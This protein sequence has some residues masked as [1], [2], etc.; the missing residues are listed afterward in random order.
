[1]G[2]ISE[3]TRLERLVA[4]LSPPSVLYKG[5]AEAMPGG[6]T[7][8]EA[9]MKRITAT[10]LFTL[11][12]MFGSLV[13]WAGLAGAQGTKPMPDCYPGSATSHLCS[14][15]VH[16]IP[17]HPGGVGAGHGSGG[18]PTSTT[19]VLVDAQ[20]LSSSSL[21]FTG[22]D[23]AAVVIV[24]LALVGSGLILVRVSRRRRIA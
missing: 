6:R 12:L 16:H 5:V 11:A 21:A 9:T 18:Q 15:P 3:Y 13:G 14:A 4:A 10:I 23:V 20:S 17:V 1:V 2:E 22:I 19:T 7:R 24:G 8:K